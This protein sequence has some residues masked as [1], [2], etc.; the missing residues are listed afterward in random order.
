MTQKDFNA[1]THATRLTATTPSAIA[2]IELSGPSAEQWLQQCWRPATQLPKRHDAIR[3]GAWTGLQSPGN[4]AD[5]SKNIQAY[6]DVVICWTAPDAVEIHCHGGVQA[7]NRILD[8]L[9]FCGAKIRS[10]EERISSQITDPYI[11]A[12]LIDLQKA[13]TEITTAIL[14]DQARGALARAMA[15]IQKLVEHHNST[16]FQRRLGFQSVRKTID[17]PNVTQLN[18]EP[19]ALS[20]GLEAASQLSEFENSEAIARIDELRSRQS[21]GLHLT[22]PWRLA[23][24]GPPNS[25]KSS[26][27]NAILGYNRAIVDPTAGTTRDALNEYTSLL[28]WPFVLVDTAGLRDTIDAIEQQGVERAHA[29]IESSDIILLLV[30]PNQGWNDRHELVYR[31]HPSKCIAVYSKADLGSVLP[32]IPSD[33]TATSISAHTRHGLETLYEI[34]LKKLIPIPPQLGQA[35]PFRNEHIEQLNRWRKTMTTST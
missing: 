17:K 24:I 27:L 29:T 35:V 9:K 5:T 30:E 18:R 8:D 34:I 33:L 10:A 21:Y 22:Q 16:S 2:V 13:T 15:E 3:Y 28:G 31:S 4:V 6:E 11:A 32:K 20:E 7:A 19:P 26:L 14:L 12:A 25:G 23:I 1:A